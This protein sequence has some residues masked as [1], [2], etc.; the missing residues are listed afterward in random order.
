MAPWRLK[1]IH[2]GR[3]LSTQTCIPAFLPLWLKMTSPSRL[4]TN[5]KMSPLW[6][7]V[8]T[9]QTAQNSL[10]STRD[11][12]LWGRSLDR[13]TLGS[14]EVTPKERDPERLGLSLVTLMKT[15]SPER[16]GRS[17]NTRVLSSRPPSERATVCSSS[18]LMWAPCSWWKRRSL[19]R[20]AGSRQECWVLT[21]FCGMGQADGTRRRCSSFRWRSQRLTERRVSS[22]SLR[23]EDMRT[24]VN[25]RDRRQLSCT[26]SLPVGRDTDRTLSQRNVI[27]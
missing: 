11:S 10:R 13:R 15:A 19:S 8:G 23:R 25:G 1:N 26:T 3:E 9:L 4:T 16:S 5:P 21:E 20:W 17:V 12:G 6:R 2:R 18:I 22:A 14:Q 27:F 7:G 24:V